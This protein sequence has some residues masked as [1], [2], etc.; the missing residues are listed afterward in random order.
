V[1]FIIK[2]G[3]LKVFSETIIKIIIITT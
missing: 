3:T 1:K 2:I